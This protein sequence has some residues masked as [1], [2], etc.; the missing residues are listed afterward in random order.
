VGVGHHPIGITWDDDTR[1]LWV[2]C[3]SGSIAV[4]QDGA[5]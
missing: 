5:A 3:Y 2:A 4:F 1:Q